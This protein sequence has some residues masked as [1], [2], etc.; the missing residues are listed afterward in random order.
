MF[1]FSIG[2]EMACKQKLLVEK[3]SNGVEKW[4]SDSYRRGPHVRVQR[5]VLLKNLSDKTCHEEYRQAGQV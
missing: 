2:K 1:S 3:M 4:L 5:K